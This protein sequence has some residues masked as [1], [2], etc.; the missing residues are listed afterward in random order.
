MPASHKIDKG[1]RF[2]LSTASGDITYAVAL[3]HQRELSADRDNFPVSAFI[4]VP[5]RVCGCS[6]RPSPCLRS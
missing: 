2:V 1:R 6:G 4:L 3:A 5:G